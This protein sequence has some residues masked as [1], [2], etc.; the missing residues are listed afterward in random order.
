[1]VLMYST[2]LKLSLM[3][4]LLEKVFC[5]IVATYLESW[6]VGAVMLGTTG[7]SGRS[8]LWAFGCP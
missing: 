1:M 5:R 6:Y 3:L 7:R 4:Y 2:K 8:G